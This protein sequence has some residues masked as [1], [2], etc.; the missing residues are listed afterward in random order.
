M[1]RNDHW[2]ADRKV[3]CGGA[4]GRRQHDAVSRVTRDLLTIDFDPQPDHA[5][6][7]A[8]VQHDVVEGVP[9]ARILD[10]SR[11]PLEHHARLAAIVSADQP[12]DGVLEILRSTG[13]QE[14]E[15]SEVDAENGNLATS[16][17]PGAAQ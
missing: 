4:G 9:A 10:E 15:A 2:A 11:P 8:L 13:A 17:K 16:Q 1:P 12:P 6:L 5:R 3:V 14:A 7:A